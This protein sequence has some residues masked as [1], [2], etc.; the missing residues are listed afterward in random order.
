MAR[1]FVPTARLTYADNACFD[2]TSDLT[3]AVWVWFTS[4]PA[5]DHEV[6]RKNGNYILRA[7]GTDLYFLWWNGSSVLRGLTT[8]LPST[9]AWHQI[10]VT[11]TSDEP[12]QVY[13]D[14]VSQGLSPVGFGGGARDL[15][16]VFYVGGSGGGEAL[17]GRLAEIGLYNSVLS[18]GQITSLQTTKPISVGTPTAYI[19]L[20]ADTDEKQVGITPSVTGTINT[21]SHPP[22]L[23]GGGGSDEQPLVKRFGGVPGLAGP[24]FYGGVGGGVW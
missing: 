10:V 12:T 14:G 13:Y 23:S 1:E 17:D 11:V 18:G 19:P 16:D 24:K 5:G 8:A 6:I 3:I 4:T 7:G 20:D 21:V 22:A 15:T 2:Y 9:G